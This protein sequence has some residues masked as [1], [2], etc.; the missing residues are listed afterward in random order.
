MQPLR[1]SI[2]ITCFP[3]RQDILFHVL[4]GANEPNIRGLIE[5][6]AI[7]IA[8][9]YP[10]DGVCQALQR[11]RPRDDDCLNQLRARFFMLLAESDAMRRRLSE[12]QP[13]PCMP[14][15]V[16]EHKARLFYDELCDELLPAFVQNQALR[17][18]E[19]VDMLREAYLHS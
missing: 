14:G 15:P 18:D 13:G 11:M 6:A 1:M 10:T 9:E 8:R 16:C 5:Q 3:G 17:V 4:Y 12:P 7:D 2:P 19:F